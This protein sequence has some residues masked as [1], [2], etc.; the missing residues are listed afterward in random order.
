M[1]PRKENKPT[2]W[3]ELKGFQLLGLTKV[4][5]YWVK[6]M[7]QL[8]YFLWKVVSMMG[9]VIWLSRSKKYKIEL[10][11]YQIMQQEF[12]KLFGHFS[13]DI[14][15]YNQKQFYLHLLFVNMLIGYVKPNFQPSQ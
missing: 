10:S 13:M 5:V 11:F 6:E 14:R 2:L 12:N 1:C 3:I 15:C 4:E 7:T 9:L 8:F